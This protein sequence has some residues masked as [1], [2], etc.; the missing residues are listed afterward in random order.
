MNHSAAGAERLMERALVQV[1]DFD[2]SAAFGHQIALAFHGLGITAAG[3]QPMAIGTECQPIDVLK[4]SLEL[5][6]GPSPFC[7]PHFRV[8]VSIDLESCQ[9]QPN[10]LIGSQNFF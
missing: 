2:V 8:L 4:V 6:S 10:S 1:P 3:D 9:S 7:I 5:E